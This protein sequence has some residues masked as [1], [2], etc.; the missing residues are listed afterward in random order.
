[1]LP[2]TNQNK[3]SSYSPICFQKSLP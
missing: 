1:M 2:K 3:I